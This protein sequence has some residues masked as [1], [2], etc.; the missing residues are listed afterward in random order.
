MGQLSVIPTSIP[1]EG[2]MCMPV[3]KGKFEL[4]GEQA[5]DLQCFVFPARGPDGG[6]GL[7]CRP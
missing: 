3:Y 5:L 2:I 7:W 6:K 4:I 1:H